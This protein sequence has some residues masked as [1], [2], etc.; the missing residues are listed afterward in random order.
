[1]F[2]TSLVAFSKHFWITVAGWSWALLGLKKNK[3]AGS[4]QDHSARTAST[5][6][7]THPAFHFG[8]GRVESARNTEQK[9]RALCAN[10]FHFCLWQATKFRVR[11]STGRAKRKKN[12]EKA[13]TIFVLR[14]EKGLLWL[15]LV[16]SFRKIWICCILLPFYDQTHGMHLILCHDV[17]LVMVFMCSCPSLMITESCRH[18]YCPSTHI[19][20]VWSPVLVCVH[21]GFLFEGNASYMLHVCGWFHHFSLRGE[22]KVRHGA[23]VRVYY[24][25]YCRCVI[26]V[27]SYISCRVCYKSS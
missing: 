19:G 25:P 11:F 18:V 13:F 3:N 10:R 27:S 24:C 22:T 20:Q 23:F 5:C 16:F 26:H 2:S 21:F 8:W 15:G 9:W 6:F 14:A 12:L 4:W 7:T 17:Q 1:M